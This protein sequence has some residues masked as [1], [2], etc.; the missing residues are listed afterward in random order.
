MEGSGDE[1]PGPEGSLQQLVKRQRKE[2]REL[3]GEERH[4]RRRA[5][6]EKTGER[7]RGHAWPAGLGGSSPPSTA[8]SPA[9]QPE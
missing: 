7:R 1:E 2:K 6:G 9:R 4:A 3:Q 8:G 5:G